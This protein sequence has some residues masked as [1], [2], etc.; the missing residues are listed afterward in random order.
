M[1][2][3]TTKMVKVCNY[4]YTNLFS[5]CTTFD[6]EYLPVVTY[7]DAAGNCSDYVLYT[8]AEFDT[9]SSGSSPFAISASEGAILGGAIL[10]VWAAAFAFKA[11]IKALNS[12]DPEN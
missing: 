9:L 5:P 12:G 2:C 8:K 7:P 3:L 10:A 4:D 11:V 6:F 1:Q